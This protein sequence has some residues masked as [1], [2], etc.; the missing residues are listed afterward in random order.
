VNTAGRYADTLEI[1]DVQAFDSCSGNPLL[2]RA[3][4]LSRSKDKSQPLGVD[5]G[6]GGDSGRAIA[7]HAEKVAHLFAEH[8]TG[9]LTVTTPL[10]GAKGRDASAEV[11]RRK[12][13]E[14]RDRIEATAAQCT[15]SA[16]EAQDPGPGSGAGSHP[17]RDLRGLPRASGTIA[18]RPLPV[19]LGTTARTLPGLEA[20]SGPLDRDGTL[21][22]GALEG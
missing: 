15:G 6:G 10:T 9:K 18:A 2:D 4:N 17:V 14:A 16:S 12:A 5:V 3:A 20:P 11:R 22:A 21:R 7:P 1:P 19:V 13:K 8:V